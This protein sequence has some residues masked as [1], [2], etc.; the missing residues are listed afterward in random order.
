MAALIASSIAPNTRRAY[1]AALRTLDADLDGEPLTDAAL[2]AHLGRRRAEGVA[3]S[4]LA[5][6]VAAANFRARLEALDPGARVSG[7][8]TDRVLA[9]AK[10]TDADRGRGQALPVR[11][12]A[13]LA[14][15]SAAGAPRRRG[16]RRE[17]VEEAQAR[18]LLDSAMIGLAFLGGLRRSE[19]AALTW[20]MVKDAEDPELLLIDLKRSKTN[21][22]GARADVR[23]V[24]GPGAMALRVLRAE[25]E[26]RGEAQRDGKVIGLSASQVNRR[27]K[28]AAAAAGMPGISAHSF[29][30]GLASEATARGASTTETMKAGGWK[31][32]RMVAHYAADAQA[33]RGAVAKYF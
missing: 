11:Y 24:K 8:L 4:T 5:L 12:E 10:R 13:V 16:R 30:V 15:Q 21:Q 6:V 33:E 3:P 27:L 20:G 26:A 32:A 9:G 18:G 22:E 31:T 19:I 2:A 1:E 17:T 23:A 29:R 25:A 14:M 28:A 7:P